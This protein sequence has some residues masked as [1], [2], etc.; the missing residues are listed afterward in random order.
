MTLWYYDDTKLLTH[1]R[2]SIIHYNGMTVCWILLELL[3]F[4]VMG[5]KQF[6]R[7]A[8][9]K[10]EVDSFIMDEFWS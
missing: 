9:P 6:L 8:L 4:V 1:Y 7:I 2:S 5:E 10:R 3:I